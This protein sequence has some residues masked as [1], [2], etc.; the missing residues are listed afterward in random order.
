METPSWQASCLTSVAWKRR[1]R[2]MVRPRDLG[3][4]KVDDQ[5][6]LHRLL[7]REVPGWLPFRIWSTWTK[8]RWMLS[9]SFR[10]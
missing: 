10:A 2:V 3:G 1:I 9:P 4:P 5:L 7:N 6:E 8:R